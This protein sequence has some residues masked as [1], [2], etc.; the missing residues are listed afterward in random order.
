[1]GVGG[2]HRLRRQRRGGAF[3]T[4]GPA[5]SLKIAT[6]RKPD[7]TSAFKE[8]GEMGRKHQCPGGRA[9]WP[10]LVLAHPLGLWEKAL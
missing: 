5:V 10:G 9:C 1:M 8:G 3:W 6:C 7:F 4:A 2:R